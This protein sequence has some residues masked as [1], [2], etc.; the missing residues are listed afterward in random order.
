MQNGVISTDLPS[1]FNQELL[2][3]RFFVALGEKD[4]TKRRLNHVL[5]GK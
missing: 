1:I 2:E 4:G 5:K 3:G